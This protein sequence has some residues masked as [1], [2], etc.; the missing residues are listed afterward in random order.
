MFVSR[1]LS[2]EVVEAKTTDFKHS[3]DMRFWVKGE[4][5]SIRNLRNFKCVRVRAYGIKHLHIKS[6]EIQGRS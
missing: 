5:K 3:G 1:R 2:L 6:L 4:K